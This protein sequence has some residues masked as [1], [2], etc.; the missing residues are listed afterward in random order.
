MPLLNDAYLHP[1]FYPL[2]IVVWC[3][4]QIFIFSHCARLRRR[5]NTSYWCVISVFAPLQYQLHLS[6]NSLLV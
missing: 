5:T 4:L 3:L 6:A 1:T 2:T